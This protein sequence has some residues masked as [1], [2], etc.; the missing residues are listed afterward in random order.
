M[1]AEQDSPT[2][3]DTGAQIPAGD[4]MEVTVNPTRDPR[5]PDGYYISVG[6]GAKPDRVHS[7]AVFNSDGTLA[8]IPQNKGWRDTPRQ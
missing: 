5:V 8:D 4:D 7:T 1:R 3:L 6:E 2:P